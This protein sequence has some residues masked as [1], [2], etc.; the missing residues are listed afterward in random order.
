MANVKISCRKKRG[1][2]F[3]ASLARQ[4][5]AVGRE[6]DAA[7]ARVLRGEGKLADLAS[8]VRAEKVSTFLTGG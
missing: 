2:T 4:L 5:G 1:E 8:I 6:G 3:L 7:A